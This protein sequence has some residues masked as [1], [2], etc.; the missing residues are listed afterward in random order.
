M[1]PA[2]LSTLHAALSAYLHQLTPRLKLKPGVTIAFRELL[3]AVEEVDLNIR[4][5]RA[6]FELSLVRRSAYPLRVSLRDF[7]ADSILA[8]IHATYP[9][10]VDDL[11][12][13]KLRSK[14]EGKPL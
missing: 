1:T 10:D 2:S 7:G 4:D 14:R 3:L 9:D 11:V 13:P 12:E 5:S 8:A 6:P